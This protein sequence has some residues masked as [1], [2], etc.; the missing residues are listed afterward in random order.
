[1]EDN[2]KYNKYPFHSCCDGC[3]WLMEDELST[4]DDWYFSCYNPNSDNYFIREDDLNRTHNDD[5][6]ECPDKEPWEK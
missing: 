2:S 5:D 4:E 1:M 6:Y 3:K